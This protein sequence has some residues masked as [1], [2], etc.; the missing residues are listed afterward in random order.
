MILGSLGA[1]VIKVECHENPDF[2]RTIGA[3]PDNIAGFN[4]SNR[5]KRDIGLNLKVEKGQEIARRLI[6]GA[7]IVGE[8]LRGGV[9]KSLN[10][11]YENVRKFKPDIIYISSNG[12]GS[13][14]PYSEYQAYGRDALRLFGTPVTLVPSHGSLPSGG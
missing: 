1:D 13:G 6:K 4:E 14:G 9:M 3:D 12:Y 10:L 5:N 2:M 11:D 7:D 8:N